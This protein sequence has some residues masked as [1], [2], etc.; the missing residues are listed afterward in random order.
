MFSSLLKRLP[1]AVIGE[2]PLPDPA[3]GC[4]NRTLDNPE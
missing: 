3:V 2:V 1:V 4:A